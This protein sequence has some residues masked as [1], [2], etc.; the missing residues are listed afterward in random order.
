LFPSH[1]P[2]L[3]SPI[4][5]WPPLYPAAIAGVSKLGVDLVVASRM[6]S[7]LAFGVS[8]GLVW[9]LGSALFGPAVG[10]ITALLLM[11]WPPVTDI[12]AMA[13]S[14]SLFAMLVLVS[15]L[16][17]V[18]VMRDRRLS[19]R[20]ALAAAG[21]GIAMAGAALTRYPGIA[22]IVVGAAALLFG[23][24][25]RPWKERRAVTLVW[26]LAAS[27]PVAVLFLRNWLVTG[28]LAGGGRLPAESGVIFHTMYAAKTIVLDGSKLLWRIAIVPEALGLDSRRI[29]PGMLGA[30]GL[31]LFGFIRSGQIRRV[32]TEALRVPMASPEGRFTL[33]IGI[34]YWAVM[35][36]VRS[37]TLFEPLNTRMMMPAYPLV[38]LI[39]VAV[40]A[41]V[42]EGLGLSRKVLA[43]T[44]ATLFVG[45]MAMAVLPRNVSAGAPSLG[46]AP[47]PVW[48]QWVAMHTP[49]HTPIVG[50]RSAD[51]NFYLQRPAYSFQVFAVYRTGNRFDRDCRQIS[52]HLSALHWE[53]AYLI[54]HAEDGEFGADVMGRRYG[55]TIAR[56]L[57]GEISLP[58]R[59]VARDPQFVAYE[60]LG[61]PW[62]CHD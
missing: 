57:R 54:L 39:A 44:V 55:A 21:G 26:F 27:V 25:R 23:L 49:P 53:H 12:A 17:T 61:L 34:G 9:L 46:P 2:K 47:P 62:E 51:F 56:L 36:I 11:A 37:L 29:A 58:V 8:V 31:L 18:P 35:V 10:A 6:V 40:L 20:T 13:L 24:P 15:V 14:E 16:L 48:V 52:R 45:S 42:M 19:I 28:T 4:A 41:A 60:M 30:A 50:N 33:V 22:F 32:L 5:L 43:W 1:V 7:I 38:L 3:P 59:L